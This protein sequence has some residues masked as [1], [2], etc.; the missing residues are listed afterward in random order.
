MS[1]N[2]DIIVFFPIYGQLAAIQKPDSW[3][4]VYK[5]YIFINNNILSYKIF[6][7]NLK[8]EPKNACFLQK[9]CWHH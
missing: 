7:Q 6:L 2:C 9:K 4:M 5:S 3:R 8:T 1:A